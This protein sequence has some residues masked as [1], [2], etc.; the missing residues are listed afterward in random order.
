MF[1]ELISRH[2]VFGHRLYSCFFSVSQ[3][4]KLQT[5]EHHQIK[6]LVPTPL[7]NFIPFYSFLPLSHS[8]LWVWL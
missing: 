1:L 5:S 4:H 7:L 2:H 6:S 8:I 3:N